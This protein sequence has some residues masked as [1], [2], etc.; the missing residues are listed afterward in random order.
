MVFANKYTVQTHRHANFPAHINVQHICTQKSVS[1]R[2]QLF[3]YTSHLFVI[4]LEVKTTRRC[5]RQEL[6]WRLVAN[7]LLT[8]ESSHQAINHKNKMSLYS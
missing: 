4:Y 7:V 5:L 6:L 1:V 8:N 3:L 2:S